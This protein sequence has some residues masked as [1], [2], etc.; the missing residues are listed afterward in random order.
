M[1]VITSRA[2]FT[3][4]SPFPNTTIDITSIHAQAY[5]EEEEEVGTIDYQIPFSVPPGISVTPRLPVALNMGG[6][7][8]D[9]LRKA[10]GGTLDLSA[11][12]KVGVQIEHY[13]ETVT[14]HGKGI[15]A[16]VKW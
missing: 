3:L 12:A 1:H 13:R 2:E 4:S 5:Y 11:V 16:R 8:G 10:I 9:A 6:I 7:G 14:Y 15:T